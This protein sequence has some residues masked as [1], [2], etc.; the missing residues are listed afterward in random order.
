MKKKYIL[1]ALLIILTCPHG[2]S[3]QERIINGNEVSSADLKWKSTVGLITAPSSDY[4]QSQFCGGILI[5][6]EWVLTAAHCVQENYQVMAANEIWVYYNSYDLD[7]LDKTGKIVHVRQIIPHSSYNEITD[8]NDIALLQLSE[9]VSGITFLELRITDPSAGS[10]AWVAG[11][12]NMSPNGNQFPNKLMEA[13]V[14][15][16]DFT[17]CNSETSYNNSLTEN[18]F[19]AIGRDN[20]KIK[21]SCQGDSGSPLIIEKQGRYEL[22][23]IVSFGGTEENKCANEDFPGVYVKVNNYL[24]WIAD[25]TGL[26]YDRFPWTMFLPAIIRKK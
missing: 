4:F 11:W 5:D 20:D 16:V 7:D 19:C 3:C 17:I 6:S 26:Q 15:I 8:N 9:Q 13:N 21:D 24:N 18:M 1:C 22:A 14:S 2:L 25:T 23:G 12:G 10:G